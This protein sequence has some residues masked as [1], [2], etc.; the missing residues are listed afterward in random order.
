[1]IYDPAVTPPKLGTKVKSKY[2]FTKLEEYVILVV[3]VAP[4]PVVAA[5]KDRTTSFKFEYILF[6]NEITLN[7]TVWLPVG[8]T[9]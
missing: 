3:V 6:F 9:I 1:M 4:A 2:E 7:F 5:V 8:G